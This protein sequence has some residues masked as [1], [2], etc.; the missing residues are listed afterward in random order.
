MEEQGG[1]P[2]FQA[3][4]GGRVGFTPPQVD[5]PPLLMWKSKWGLET[6]GGQFPPHGATH[7]REGES[8]SQPLV[9]D[10]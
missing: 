7:R 1:L 2:C 8:T 3:K 10:F 9:F 6:A 4:E 5:V